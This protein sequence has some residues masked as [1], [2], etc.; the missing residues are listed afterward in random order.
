MS[1]KSQAVILDWT[2]TRVDGTIEKGYG[3]PTPIMRDGD[4]FTYVGV[5]VVHGEYRVTKKPDD[6]TG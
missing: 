3:R 4:L 1:D 5:L 6:A 2:L